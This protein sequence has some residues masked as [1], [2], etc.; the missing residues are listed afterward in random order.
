MTSRDNYYTPDSALDPIIPILRKSLPPKD[1]VIWEPFAGTDHIVKYLHKKGYGVVGTDIDRGQDFFKFEP[2]FWYDAIISNPP[3]SL[4]T[5]VLQKCFEIGKPFLLL[6]PEN[7]IGSQA[8]YNLF[9]EYGY[10]LF[11]LQTRTNYSGDHAKSTS[12]FHSHWIGH[13][14]QGFTPNTIHYL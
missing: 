11:M 6:L 9:K 3:F 13:N 4:K 8:R 10:N 14:L 1:Y 7:T 5:E 2:D 12:N